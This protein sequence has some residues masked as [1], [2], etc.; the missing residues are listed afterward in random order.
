MKRDFRMHGGMIDFSG[1]R[2]KKEARRRGY[3]NSFIGI[4]HSNPGMRKA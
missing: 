4:S 3:V 1:V 2:I